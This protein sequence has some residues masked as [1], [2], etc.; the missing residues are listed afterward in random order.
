[1]SESRMI[2]YQGDS[3]TSLNAIPTEPFFEGWVAVFSAVIHM[4]EARCQLD[5]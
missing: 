2:A 5:S 1:M 3:R 4:G